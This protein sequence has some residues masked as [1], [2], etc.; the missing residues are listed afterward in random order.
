VRVVKSVN[1]HQAVAANHV[2]PT[3]RVIVSLHC[4]LLRHVLVIRHAHLQHLF[5]FKLDVQTALDRQV[6]N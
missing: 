3:Q 6:A 1:I 5:Y 4:M 2:P